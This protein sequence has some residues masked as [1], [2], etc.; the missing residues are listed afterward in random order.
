[1]NGSVCGSDE[2]ALFARVQKF[3]VDRRT[4]PGAHGPF[5][6]AEIVVD[7]HRA[8]GAL[9]QRNVVN[10]AAGKFLHRVLDGEYAVRLPGNKVTRRTPA[11]PDFP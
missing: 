1:L 10:V 6:G 7:G 3:T 8:V 9:Q 4:K 2:E 11:S 5:Y